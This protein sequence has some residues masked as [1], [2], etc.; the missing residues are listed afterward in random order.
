MKKYLWMRSA[1]VGIGALKVKLT[2]HITLRKNEK[3]FL[4]FSDEKPT[5]K[6]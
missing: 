2:N 4:W 6:I 3:I 1:A 5:Q